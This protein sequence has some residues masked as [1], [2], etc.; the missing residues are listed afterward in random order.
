MSIP[1]RFLR[2]NSPKLLRKVFH[3]RYQVYCHECGFLSPDDYPDGLEI[4]QYDPQSIH[5]AALDHED[6][7][8]GTIRMIMNSE[9]TPF[10][11]EV[12][13]QPIINKNGFT[14]NH[15]VE[16]SRLAM[17]KK[18]RRRVDDN[19][20]GMGSYPFAKES[21]SK[22]SIQLKD[23]CRRRPEIVL[24]LYRVI[25]YEC[26]RHHLTHCFA[27]MERKLWGIL[28]RVGIPFHQ[29]GEEVDYYGP[30]IPYVV[31]ISELE[32]HIYQVNP[33]LYHYFLEGLEPHYWPEFIRNEWNSTIRSN[34]HAYQIG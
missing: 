26:K 34:V 16:I 19:L 21:S 18:Y 22:D 10:P 20:I 7:V 2:V 29:I 17:S 25:Y 33:L 12:H 31:S 30:V 27:M 1:F 13:C 23:Y 9:I 8:V 15:I 28:N 32:S 11:I 14:R 24:G 3:L 4:D 6:T 5:F